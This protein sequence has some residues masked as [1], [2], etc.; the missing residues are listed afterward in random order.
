MP[1]NTAFRVLPSDGQLQLL[2]RLY[3][4]VYRSTYRFVYRSVYRPFSLHGRRAAPP[5]ELCDVIADPLIH[6]PPL[7]RR[8]LPLGVKARFGDTAENT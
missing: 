4:S 7:H 3:R 6:L 8:Y 1:E 5:H 2:G